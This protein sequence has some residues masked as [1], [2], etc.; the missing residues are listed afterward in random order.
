M[1]RAMEHHECVIC[2]D[3]LCTKPVVALYCADGKRSCRHYFHHDCLVGPEEHVLM[4]RRDCPVC[5]AK[6]TT[7]VTVPSPLVDPRAFFDLIDVDSGG[8]LSK[9]EVLDGLKA[10]VD[11][12]WRQIDASVDAL[13]ST[14]DADG[15]GTIS[16][17]EMMRPG[18]GLLD[19]IRRNYPGQEDKRMPP[20]LRQSA[21]KWFEFWDEDSSRSLEKDEVLRAL[22]KTFRVQH[23]SV[24]VSSHRR[25]HVSLPQI[26]HLI[27]KHHHPPPHLHPSPGVNDTR[28]HRG[29]VADLRS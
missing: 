10:T 22:V 9:N 6:W 11:L 15:N 16:Y 18:T 27:S 26:A 17:E 23:G 5:R 2:F 1:D 25:V 19:Y 12:D 28:Y 21:W 14:W 29:D 8:T 24:E 3:G 13:W 7:A 20:D 4:L